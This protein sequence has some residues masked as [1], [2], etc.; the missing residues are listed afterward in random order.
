VTRHIFSRLGPLLVAVVLGACAT[1]A[2]GTATSGT[3]NVITREDLD[4]L[5]RLNLYQAVQ[6]LRPQWLQTRGMDSFEQDNEVVV[7][8]DNNR[9]GGPEEL[10]RL[11][12]IEVG[13][14][15]YLDSRQATTQFGR[16]HPSGA[17]LVFTER[18]P[19]RVP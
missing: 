2:P 11:N 4:D 14:V 19:G 16:G 12:P 17:I 8:V 7:Y 1:G 9:M 18:G 5:Q 6:R 15:R 13:E 3:G 10:R